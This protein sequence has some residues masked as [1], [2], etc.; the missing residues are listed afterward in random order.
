MSIG[1]VGTERSSLTQIQL[2]KQELS[3][4]ASQSDC[5][6]GGAGDDRLSTELNLSFQ[7]NAIHHSCEYTAVKGLDLDSP[8]EQ[9]SLEQR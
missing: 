6:S 8:L 4:I 5:L 1:F 2:A 3:L 7:T 9:L